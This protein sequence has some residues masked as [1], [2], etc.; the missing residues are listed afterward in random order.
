MRI[1]KENFVAGAVAI[2]GAF[3][4]VAI[5]LNHLE[6]GLAILF[7]SIILLLFY[8][9]KRT[10]SIYMPDL[11]G[12]LDAL[13][14]AYHALPMPKVL[15]E[16]SAS[17][18]KLQR[19]ITPVLT[20]YNLGD[21]HAASTLEKNGGWI[22]RIGTL[23]SRALERGEDVRKD[24]SDLQMDML[25]EQELKSKGNFY[26]R[27]A[28]LM[29]ILGITLFIPAFSGISLGI[30]TY[31]PSIGGAARISISSIALIFSAFIVIESLANLAWYGTGDKRHEVAF[32]SIC[33]A[34][35]LLVLRLVSS[36]AVSAI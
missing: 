3:A 7:V 24:V 27:N 1:D 29:S 28:N 11:L 19:I 2:L 4:S 25:A 36:L 33:C 26:A 12:F 18:K 35:G 9:A 30:L 31:A 23:I 13:I 34:I 21:R 20:A 10:P 17:S 5:I 15:E 8:R 32:T 22:G 14:K 6:E 16:A